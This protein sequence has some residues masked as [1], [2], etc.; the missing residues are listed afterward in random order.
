M[1]TPGVRL[2][3]ARAIN[4]RPKVKHFRPD[5]LLQGFPPHAGRV[6]WGRARARGRGTRAELVPKASTPLS[7]GIEAIAEAASG[8]QSVRSSVQLFG[9]NARNL[10]RASPPAYKSPMT[11]AAPHLRLCHHSTQFGCP[12]FSAACNLGV[13]PSR[14][15]SFR[16][17]EEGGFLS[18]STEASA[19]FHG[20][21]WW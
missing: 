8:P 14:L 19:L 21:I 5:V 2:G 9:H 12:I 3:P 17:V 16:V 11:P 7:R 6:G 13:I 1:R 18:A 4:T 10:L 20:R 15:Q